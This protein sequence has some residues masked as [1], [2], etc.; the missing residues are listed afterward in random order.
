MLSGLALG[1]L[2]CG[3]NTA[4]TQAQS[5][6]QIVVP[7]SGQELTQ[8]GDDFEDEKWKFFP[9]GAKSSEEIDK[10]QRLPLGKS[11]NGRWYEGAKRGYPDV[12][13]RVPTPPGGI[14]G[15]QGAMLL[16]SKYTGVPG[17]ISNEVQQ[18]DFIANVQYKTG[19]P[20][21]VSQCP[22]FVTRVY[23]PPIQ[24]WENRSGPHFAFRSAIETTKMEKGKF[25]FSGSHEEDEIYW[26]G[27]FILL[28]TRKNEQGQNERN[29][30]FRVRADRNG[31][32]FRGPDL[33]QMGWWT[34][35]LSYSSDG[36]V[37]Y[38]AKPGVEDLT[39][40]DYIASSLPYGYRCERV[41]TFFYNTINR[42]DGHTW[43]TPFIVDDP[44][45][46]V[47]YSGRTA[48][49]SSVPSSYRD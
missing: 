31:G 38:F 25:F 42:E 47:L 26:P 18:D 13:Q 2:C 21:S 30:F 46:F 40:A 35:G 34:L 5:A 22:S 27:L 28:E 41:R 1:L 17:R 44:K 45:V 29:A 9:N 14:V 10:Q 23:M 8:V 32:D 7:G 43:S 24:E 36:V 4:T 16:Q 20:L 33:P 37:H 48:S 19:G 39:R 6:S 12:A 15:S 3:P 49:L 11:S